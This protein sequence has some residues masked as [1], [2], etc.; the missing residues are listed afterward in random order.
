MTEILKYKNYFATVH[1]SSEENLYFGK[2]ED[3]NDLVTFE[4]D[5]LAGLK[6]FF[7][8]AVD[9]YLETCKEMGKSPDEE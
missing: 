9:D 5:S 7:I 4:G 6:K 1:Y 2:I 8:E 3:I